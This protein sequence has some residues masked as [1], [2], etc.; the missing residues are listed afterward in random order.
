M[1]FIYGSWPGIESLLLLISGMFNAFFVYCLSRFRVKMESFSCIRSC[2]NLADYMKIAEKVKEFFHNEG[3]HSTT[4]Q[5]EFVEVSTSK[6]FPT[7]LALNVLI[8]HSSN[9]ECKSCMLLSNVSFGG[10]CNSDVSGFECRKK[11]LKY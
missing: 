4:I 8:P 1:S 9:I 5:P 2:R 3:I 11:T 6:Y 10:R 7:S